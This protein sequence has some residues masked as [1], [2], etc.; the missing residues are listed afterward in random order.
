MTRRS[1]QTCVH[2]AHIDRPFAGPGKLSQQRLG[3]L[4]AGETQPMKSHVEATGGMQDRLRAP[5]KNR[6]RV[7]EHKLFRNPRQG[8]M[9]SANLQHPD[10]C[11]VKARHLRCKEASGLHRR[12]IAIIEVAGN[13]ERVDAFREAK[14][15]DR[16][17]SLPTSVSDKARRDQNFALPANAMASRDGCRPYVRIEMP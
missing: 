8:V 5:S 2:D 7:R 4:R 11:L 10:P 9:V 14:I 12:L 15:N 1:A 16:N 17:E 13:D 3:C 6:Y